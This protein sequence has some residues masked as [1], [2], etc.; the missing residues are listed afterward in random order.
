MTDEQRAA[1]L[2]ADNLEAAAQ[3]LVFY[4]WDPDLARVEASHERGTGGD[5]VRDGVLERPEV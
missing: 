2:A 3:V 4:G 5:V 1:V